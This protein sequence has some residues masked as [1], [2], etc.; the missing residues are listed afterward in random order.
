MPQT[1]VQY[2]LEQ[3]YEWYKNEYLSIVSRRN[4]HDLGVVELYLCEE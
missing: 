1:S 3:M 4:I 2:G